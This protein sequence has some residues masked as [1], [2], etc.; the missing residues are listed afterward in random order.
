[1]F[2]LSADEDRQ[3]D[4]VSS[5][6]SHFEPLKSQISVQAQRRPEYENDAFV[7]IILLMFNVFIPM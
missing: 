3:T 1:M 5:L 2:C 4:S 7:T 6:T